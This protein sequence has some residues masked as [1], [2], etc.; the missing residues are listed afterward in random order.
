MSQ[1]KEFCERW[2]GLRDGRY[3][4]VLDNGQCAHIARYATKSVRKHEDEVCFYVEESKIGNK[5]VFEI[6]NGLIRPDV[7]EIIS[8][9][10][11]LSHLTQLERR[12]LKEWYEYYIPMLKFIKDTAVKG[13][14]A[15]GM[16]ESNLYLPKYP[17]SF[18]IPYSSDARLKSFEALTREIHE[19]WIILRILKEFTRELDFIWFRQSS[20]MP[21]AKIGGY[22]LWYE[23]D[24]TPH[25][26]CEG[27][28]Q[29]YCGSFNVETCK[30][31]LPRWLSQ[32]YSRA[33]EMLKRPH[34][35]AREILGIELKG[36]RP[37]IMFTQAVG[38]CRDLFESSTL[39]I[40][41]VIECKNFDYEFWAAD[42]EKQI[43]PYKEIL[44]PEYMVLA[45]L[46]T[47]PQ[48][49]KKRL[50]SLNIEVIDNVYP[51]GVGE[52]QLIDYVKHVLLS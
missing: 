27:I 14:G 38:S 35:R 11:D 44:Q 19:V 43:I 2:R 20:A 6:Y 34:S 50:K 16:L 7:I 47:V 21:V 32:I 23:F 48:D 33:H 26:M 4:Y 29:Y 3:Y 30:E 9:C 28:L 15:S 40:K 37:D 13:I 8:K 42:V 49:A 46:K 1:I 39:Q 41:L 45:S 25:T 24:F 12:F 18:F 5:I 22:S 10:V 36:L 51:G 17:L 31:P 52:K